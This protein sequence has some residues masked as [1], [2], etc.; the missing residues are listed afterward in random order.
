MNKK[1]SFSLL[2]FVL[3][4]ASLGFSQGTPALSD[5]E[6]AA[7]EDLFEKANT[8][9]ANKE[10]SAALANYQ[11]AL[12]ALPGDPAILYN[13]GFAAMLSKEFVIAAELL[14]SVKK[15][16]PDDWQVRAKLI[17]VFQALGK[18]PERDREREE[19]IALWKK[20]SNEELKEQIEFCRER[21]TAGGRDVM[22]F[23][24]FEFKGPRGMRYIFRVI[25]ESG[26]EDH[27]ISLGSYDMTN[28]IWQETSKPKPK[29]GVRLFHL[30]GY[31]PNGH[32]T[33]G[34][35]PGEPT[36]EETRKLV[37]DILEKNEKPISAT[38]QAQP[39]NNDPQKDQ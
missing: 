4:L 19:L 26:N 5:K 7:V 9:L 14:N 38:I 17:Q 22:A 8:Q 12:K 28:A 31:F 29:K 34:M 23:E 30:D 37:V 16:D 32:A 36:Y 6:M 25:N 10:Y 11:T 18:I 2:I 21:F 35:F 3:L 27:R 13:A 1:T 24:L 33:Y 20:G 15:L 39:Q